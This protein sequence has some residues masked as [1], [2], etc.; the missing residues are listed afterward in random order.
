MDWRFSCLDAFAEAIRF[1][2]AAEV[3]AGGMTQEFE[4]RFLPKDGRRRRRDEHQ[5][6][7]RVHL[8]CIK[9]AG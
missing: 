4:V 6:A 2:T 8:K 1:W 7:K 5:S 3:N 9:Y